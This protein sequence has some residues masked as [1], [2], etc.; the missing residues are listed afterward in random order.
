M[1]GS[2][3]DKA[4]HPDDAHALKLGQ[5]V[6]ESRDRSALGRLRI[7][8]AEITKQDLVPRVFIALEQ[9]G[10][11]MLL[12]ERSREKAYACQSAV[13][14]KVLRQHHTLRPRR[15]TTLLL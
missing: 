2:W 4:S 15:T 3:L 6:F 8:P 11:P 5:A 14:P 9:V 10:P 7:I 1:Q 12:H 13:K